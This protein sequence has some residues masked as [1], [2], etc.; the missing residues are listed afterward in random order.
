MAMMTRRL[1][2]V[3]AVVGLGA[4]ATVLSCSGRRSTGPSPVA[5]VSVAHSGASF[6]QVGSSLQLS[7]TPLDIAGFPVVGQTA[8]WSSSDPTIAAVT[9]GG[10]VTAVAPGTA[11]MTATCNGRSGTA[12]I[13]VQ[14]PLA[15]L[16]VEQSAVTIAAGASLSLTVTPEDHNGGA[17]Q[18]VAFTWSSSNTAVATVTASGG[19][20]TA[21]APG[22]TTITVSSGGVSATAAITVVGP[23]LTGSVASVVV[24]PAALSFEMGPQGFSGV[25]FQLTA[26]TADPNGNTVTGFP[27][28]WSSSD[29]TI[30]AVSSTGLLTPSPLVSKTSI[31]TIT[32][33]CEGI[34]GTAAITVNPPVAAVTLAPSSMNLKVGASQVLVALPTD[35]H[36]QP[37]TEVT[38]SWTNYNANIVRLDRGVDSVRVTALTAGVERVFVSDLVNSASASIL[39]TV[40]AQLSAT[41]ATNS[42]KRVLSPCGNATARLQYVAPDVAATIR[43]FIRSRTNGRIVGAAPPTDYC[44]VTYPVM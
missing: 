2:V 17:L 38:L 36:G 13:I 1:F 6:V 12:A 43:R 27:I 26:T 24:R 18:G 22:V 44:T 35:A 19:R 11:S 16:A 15:T 41:I 14:L 42:R 28:V 39:I 9:A 37:M 31:A 7:A 25:P 4:T 3:T 30:A 20:V 34:S 32:A 8:T 21:V 29:T 5:S 23:G 33:T 40:S 10:L